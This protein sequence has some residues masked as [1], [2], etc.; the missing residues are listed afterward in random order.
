MVKPLR[1]PFVVTVAAALMPAACSGSAVVDQGSGGSSSGAQASQASTTDS[2]VTATS[3]TVAVS[4]SSGDPNCPGNAPGLYAQCDAS[5]Q[6]VC[7]YMIACQSGSEV[8]GFICKDNYWAPAIQPCDWE[9]DSCPGTDLYCTNGQWYMPEGTNPPSPCPSTAPE[10]GSECNAFDFGGTWGQCG[11]A[12]DG[13]DAS[14]GWIVAT[15]GDNQNPGMWSYDSV[16][17]D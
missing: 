12:C 5:S 2:S 1:V 7:T 15:C 4:S 3:S 9:Y 11:Y 17:V 8:I 14:S 13:K 16:C 6:T 10:G